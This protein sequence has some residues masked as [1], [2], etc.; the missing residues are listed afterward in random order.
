MGLSSLNIPPLG[1][2][3]AHTQQYLL[4]SHP[5]KIFLMTGIYLDAAGR[6]GKIDAVRKAEKILFEQHPNRNYLMPLGDDA[7][8]VQVTKLLLHR[9]LDAQS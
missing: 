5:E 2:R 3:F 4:D 8:R 1:G 6:C 7:Y 9:E